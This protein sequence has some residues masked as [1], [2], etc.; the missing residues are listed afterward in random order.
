[1]DLVTVGTAARRLLEAAGAPHGMKGERLYTRRWIAWVVA[2][3][4]ADRRVAGFI[5]R[6][7]ENE[8]A[9]AALSAQQMIGGTASVMESVRLYLEELSRDDGR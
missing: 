9:L 5:R 8:E 2:A 3:A 4:G 6:L 1:M 7:N